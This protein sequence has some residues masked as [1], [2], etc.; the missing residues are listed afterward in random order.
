MMKRIPKFHLTQINRFWKHVKRS[1]KKEACWFWT[2]LRACL[3]SPAR[4]EMFIARRRS[5][6]PSQ[7]RRGG[8]AHMPLLTELHLSGL[9]ARY[10]HAAPDGADSMLTF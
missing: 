8:T 6:F 7:P 1:S 2:G 9:A 3:K 5:L 10:T 4:G